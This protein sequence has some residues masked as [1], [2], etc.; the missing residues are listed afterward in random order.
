MLSTQPPPAPTPCG[1]PEHKKSQLMQNP[2][3]CK[4]SRLRYVDWGSPTTAAF[5]R[6]LHLPGVAN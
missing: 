5:S 3:S 2:S 4:T 6:Y 1:H